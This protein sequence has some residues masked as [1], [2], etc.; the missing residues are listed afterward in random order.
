MERLREAGNDLVYRCA[1]QHSEP[2]G[3]RRTDQREV[4]ADELTLTTLSSIWCISCIWCTSQ[5]D[6]TLR[7]LLPLLAF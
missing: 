5:W 3:D 1:K 7:S 6:N 4:K 2:G